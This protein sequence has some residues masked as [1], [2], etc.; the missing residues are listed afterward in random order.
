MRYSAHEISLNFFLMMSI[1]FDSVPFLPSSDGVN[2]SANVRRADT[3][4]AVA[5]CG[6]LPARKDASI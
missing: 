4:F 5:R 3:S 6:G 2:S 1:S